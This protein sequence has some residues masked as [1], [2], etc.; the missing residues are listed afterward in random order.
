M[1]NIM[2]DIT[3]QTAFLPNLLS[4]L[5]QAPIVSNRA[6]T[7][8]DKAEIGRLWIRKDTNKVYALTSI[9]AGSSTWSILN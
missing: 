4:G 6:P 9:S 1:A 5:S 3:K 8:N 7:A 2:D